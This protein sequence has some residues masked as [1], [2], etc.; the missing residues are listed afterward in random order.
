MKASA[1]QRLRDRIPDSR[2]Q[3]RSAV[4]VVRDVLGSV[5]QCVIGAGGCERV[6]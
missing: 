6:K 5:V 1:G 3:I 4:A 2:S